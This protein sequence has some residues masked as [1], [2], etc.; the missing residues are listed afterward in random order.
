MLYQ[1]IVPVVIAGILVAGLVRGVPVF[2]AFT[3]GVKEGLGVIYRIFP[4]L[5]GLLTAI[6]MF[7]ASGGFELVALMLRPVAGLLH[8]PAELLPVAAVRPMS[9]SGSIALLQELMSV[10]GADSFIG[11]AAAVMGASTETSVYVIAVYMGS[12]GIKKT[13]GVLPVA[14]SADLVAFVVSVASVRFF[15]GG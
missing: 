14:L 12:T 2:D 11:R 7:R 6:A 13:G 3:E 5:V 8:I 1:L 9:G 4:V 10:H 15:F